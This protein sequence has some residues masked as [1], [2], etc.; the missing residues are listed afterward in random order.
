[1]NLLKDNSNTRL[2]V[3]M[4]RR[5]HSI[6]W[7]SQVC[8]T[9]WLLQRCLKKNCQYPQICAALSFT[10]VL[11]LFFNFSLSINVIKVACASKSFCYMIVSIST[12][13]VPPA[14]CPGVLLRR[15]RPC[16]LPGASRSS[17]FL[18]PS[19][20]RPLSAPAG[21]SWTPAALIV[22]PLIHGFSVLTGEQTKNTDINELNAQINLSVTTSR[23]YSLQV[24]FLK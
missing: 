4:W 17:S 9:P 12:P 2:S 11:S 10:V 7:N 21:S 18:C 20:P 23:T 8:I 13:V 5:R 15:A 3:K 1:M 19:F 14:C 16:S 22:S 6:R 24:L